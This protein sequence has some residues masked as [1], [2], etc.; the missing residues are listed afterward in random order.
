[1]AFAQQRRRPTTLSRI[2]Y[3]S[4]NSIA[5]SS[6]SED[7]HVLSSAASSPILFPTSESETSRQSD[8]E[9]DFQTSGD[10]AAY[11]PSHDGTGTFIVE[12]TEFFSSD[13]QTTDESEDDLKSAIEN[14]TSDQSI[15][16]MISQQGS[17]PSFATKK[18]HVESL[19]EPTVIEAM[20][21]ADE[22]KASDVSDNISEKSLDR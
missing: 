21:S 20:L 17:P 5:I 10:D 8:T 3:D 19:F 4:N 14:L 13:Q 9:S 6:D 15:L 11:L 12:D 16:E 18:P 7:W 1:M 22:E 2:N